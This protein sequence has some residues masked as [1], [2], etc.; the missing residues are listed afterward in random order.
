MHPPFASLVCTLL[1]QVEKGLPIFLGL[2]GCRCRNLPCLPFWSLA[3]VTGTEQYLL[4]NQ[5]LLSFS[6]QVE[7]MG[8]QLF[9]V[10]FPVVEVSLGAVGNSGLVR[11]ALPCLSYFAPHDPLL[12]GV[13]TTAPFKAL[14]LELNSCSPMPSPHFPWGF[15]QPRGPRWR[16][17]QG[18]V[19]GQC[20]LQ[21]CVLIPAL[22]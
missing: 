19:T 8:H 2:L 9:S 10:A 3:L 11:V 21:L 7:D 20:G 22:P 5:W 16:W 13:G 14:K 6:V 15:N 4:P 12:A 18:F 1:G 17:G